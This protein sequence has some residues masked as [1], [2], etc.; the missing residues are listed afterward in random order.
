MRTFK[1]AIIEAVTH[2]LFT[3][4]DG[5]IYDF[6]I[7]IYRREHQTVILSVKR[8]IITYS[9]IKLNTLML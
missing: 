6:M 2:I 5:V 7:D 4:N 3:A 8:N 9:D 1:S